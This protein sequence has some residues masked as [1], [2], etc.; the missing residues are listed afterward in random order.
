MFIFFENQFEFRNWLEQYSLINKELWVGFYKKNTSKPT[1]TW[2]ESVDQALCFGWIDGI[3]KSIDNESYTIRFT[4]RNPKSNWS[5]VNIKKVEELQKA[6]LMKPAGMKLFEERSIEKSGQYSFE[7]S[8]IKLPEEYL[9]R[10]NE[11]KT[12]WIF[13]NNS[14][15]SYR[16]AA[17]QWVM[18]AKM[19]V[20]R[21]KR[22]DALIR[23][24]AD[25]L[26][27]GILRR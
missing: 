4:P 26:K 19:E 20:T 27:V 23:D 3:R 17:L 2:P 11:N 22:L 13:F 16:K 18:N 25:K 24:S 14:P 15:P 21:L 8:L 1:L 5:L 12:A 7:Q 9:I 10:F 6:G